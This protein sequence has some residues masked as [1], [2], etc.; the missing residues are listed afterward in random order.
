[1]LL[2]DINSVEP[3]KKITM[4]GSVQSLSFNPVTQKLFIGSSKDT[5]IYSH[6]SETPVDRKDIKNKVTSSQWS[7]DG[8]LLAFG[9]VTGLVAIKDSNFEKKVNLQKLSGVTCLRWSP[10]TFDQPEMVL[11]VSCMDQTISFHNEEGALLGFEKKVK[12][13]ITAIEWFPNSEYFLAVGSSNFISVFSR[14]GVLLQEIDSGYEWLWTVSM[15]L[16]GSL[17]TVGSNKGEIKVYS[18]NFPNPQAIYG[19]RFANR[20]GFTDVLI[21]DLVSDSKAKFKCKELIKNISLYKDMMAI[22]STTRVLLFRE[23]QNTDPKTTGSK[24]EVLEYKPLSKFDRKI[25]GV[26]FTLLS[27][28]IVIANNN[29]ISCYDFDRNLSREWTFES[30]ITFLKNIGGPRGEDCILAGFKNGTIVKIFIS[31][32]FAIVLI[33]HGVEITSLDMSISKKLLGT[34][35]VKNNFYLY[36]YSKI[37]TTL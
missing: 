7:S 32:P 20:V 14:E 25:E 22:H 1:M 37:V 24:N 12:C 21:R 26:F 19:S 8:R 16:R 13:E 27:M 29:R 11:V 6:N 33:E 36:I 35:D 5:V 15:D 18:V 2:W 28:N 34:V 23:T 10:V 30:N 4:E 3:K 31:N 9:T 17:F